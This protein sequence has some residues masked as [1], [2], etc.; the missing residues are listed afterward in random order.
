MKPQ[1]DELKARLKNGTQQAQ[2]AQENAD[3]AEKEAAAA[4]EVRDRLY[5]V[6]GDTYALLT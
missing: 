1:L 2:D 5:T 4:N 3:K 6:K